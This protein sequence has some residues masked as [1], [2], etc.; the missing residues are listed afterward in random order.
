M[1]HI[2]SISEKK[3]DILGEVIKSPSLPKGFFDM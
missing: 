3:I 1:I 2:A